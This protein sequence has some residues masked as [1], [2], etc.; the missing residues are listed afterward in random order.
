MKQQF[1]VDGVVRHFLNDKSSERANLVHEITSA[2]RDSR[3]VRELSSTVAHEAMQAGSSPEQVIGIGLMYGMVVGI[4][5]E[6]LRERVQ[7]Q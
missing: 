4:Y 7:L 3:A 2:F 5:L 1:D 6:K